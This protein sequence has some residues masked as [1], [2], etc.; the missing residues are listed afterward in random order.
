MIKLIL[1]DF[2]GTIADTL[3]TVVNLYNKLAP[4]NNM[5]TVSNSQVQILRNQSAKEIIKEFKISPIKIMLIGNSIRK[6]VK[7]NIKDIPIFDG[8]DLLFNNLK[9]KNIKIGILTSNSKEN[10]ELFLKNKKINSVDFIHGEKNIFGKAK[11]IEKVIK[12][13]QISKND[14][15]Y[16]GDEVRDIESAHK[17]KIKIISVSWG[18]NSKKRLKAANPDYLVDNPNEILNIVDI[19]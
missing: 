8:I 9:K 17:A 19:I 10:V 6:E 15:I 4:E 16:V 11:V 18:F 14:V 12:N 1:F 2:D 7:E 3:G 5:P 13:E